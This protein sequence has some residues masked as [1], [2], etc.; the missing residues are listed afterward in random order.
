MWMQPKL[1]SKGGGILVV[2]SFEHTVAHLL[3]FT[4]HGLWLNHGN[5]KTNSYSASH[6]KGDCGA[7][8][9]TVG[10]TF[11]LIWRP[12]L[13]HCCLHSYIP[14]HG[15]LSFILSIWEVLDDAINLRNE[16]DAHVTLQ[17]WLGGSGKGK[18][19]KKEKKLAD[20]EQSSFEPYHGHREDPIG[21]SVQK[22]TLYSAKR[23]V[24]HVFPL[25]NRK[26]VPSDDSGKR[27]TGNNHIPEFS[28]GEKS[29]SLRIMQLQPE[30]LP[31]S[32]WWGPLFPVTSSYGRVSRRV[33]SMLCLNDLGVLWPKSGLS[34][35]RIFLLVWIAHWKML[36]LDS[37]EVCSNTFL[38]SFDVRNSPTQ[39][40]R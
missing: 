12:L 26:R 31:T 4:L 36:K 7:R 21:T 13:Q 9:L 40:E 18:K 5:W 2:R 35:I 22:H 25:E 6:V 1:S 11:S 29:D 14:V 32:H 39:T 24:K 27:W 19:R 20:P 3:V 15:S 37:F 28:S 16:R 8:E 33:D 10:Q 23:T 17:Q 30:S 34:Q 38:S